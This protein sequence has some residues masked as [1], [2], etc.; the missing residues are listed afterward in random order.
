M[1]NVRSEFK[2]A[3]KNDN[4]KFE[5]EAEI[6]LKNNTVLTITNEELWSQG[7]EIEDAISASD[8]FD[9]GGFII[10]SM[11][12]VI[13][14]IYED[15][16]QY[17]FFDANVN[18]TLSLDCGNN[19]TENIAFND[20]TVDEANDNAAQI[21]LHC[22]N[23]AKFFERP[24]SDSQLTYT[25]HTTVNDIVQDACT[26]CGVQLLTTSIDGGNFV[27]SKRPTDEKL[28]FLKVIAWC[29]QLTGNYARI[30]NLGQ[31]VVKWFDLTHYEGTVLIP[32]A[33]TD[34]DDLAIK[35]TDTEVI[36]D[37]NATNSTAN[38]ADWTIDDDYAQYYHHI[39]SWGE[40]HTGTDDV[41]IT[42][43]RVVVEDDDGNEVVKTSGSAGYILE[44]RDNE[45]I[46]AEL[47]QT[48]A[49]NLSSK[50]VGMQF[51]TYN[52]ACLGDPTV[53][54]GDL[55]WVTDRKGR[56]YRSFV[57]GH[58]FKLGQYQ[59]IYCG[60]KSPSRN[61]AKGYSATTRA[62]VNARKAS[63]REL[64][65]YEARAEA[66]TK[67]I[68]RGFGVYVT[69]VPQQDGSMIPYIHDKPT[70]EGSSYVCYMTSQGVLM[71]VDGQT[72]VAVDKNGNA[73]LNTLTARG[74]NADWINTGTIRSK[75]GAV[76]IN[77][78]N[79]TITLTGFVKATDLGANGSTTIDGARIT[80]G[81][82]QG[83]G[84]AQ[85]PNFKL[86]MSDGALTMKKGSINIGNGKFEVDTNGNLTAKSA[87]I[88]GTIK[89]STNSA[90]STITNGHVYGGIVRTNNN[91]T[92]ETTKGY[93]SFNQ[94]YSDTSDYGTRIAGKS[95]IALLAPVIGV[96][97]YKEYDE[98][99]TIYVG[100]TKTLS[101]LVA[102]T[103]N[104]PFQV[105]ATFNLELNVTKDYVIDYNGN[106]IQ[107]VTGV[108]LRRQ[109]GS[110]KDIDISYNFPLKSLDFNK[111]LL[112]SVL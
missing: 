103:G 63:Q 97:T 12:L 105:N 48:V 81:I 77:L 61:S 34:T 84:T 30:N 96:G 21:V 72:T 89:S 33:I 10:G 59:S 13:N 9:V 11:R 62:I 83:G 1:L 8:S 68:S 57:T 74:I 45:L 46:S 86:V 67:L 51:R 82:I 91:V 85:N 87:D 109:S 43:I 23:T 16:T 19:V 29:A 35:D 24:Y 14:N 92:T 4:R 69:E 20:Y 32:G 49:N 18:V 6:T 64:L 31:L 66:L 54:C 58:I 5:I 98:S 104:N 80:T 2:Q 39:E 37:V 3:L 94:Y 106:Y 108:S 99:A 25:S 112:T 102:G 36:L 71:E 41:V 76:S 95:M 44:I 111:G 22:L 52:G 60:A 101:V 56:S 73:L 53:E 7:F 17:D 110:T 79:E 70:I 90:F 38:G 78:D 75:N 42:G 27:V 88:S 55:A 50:I 93:I 28:T 100:Q 15:Y 47:A 65:S 107:V 40:L 26:V